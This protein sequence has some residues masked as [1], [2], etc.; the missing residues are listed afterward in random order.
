MAW[1]M[2]IFKIIFQSFCDFSDIR[3]LDRRG[4]NSYSASKNI[5]GV[6][7]G[8]IK[9]NIVGISVSCRGLAD[10]KQIKF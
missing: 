6:S 2:E 7:F 4:K 8:P 5:I 10:I 9:L 1:F 3:L